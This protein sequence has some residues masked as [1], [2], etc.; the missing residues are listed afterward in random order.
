M[1]TSSSKF[2]EAEAMIPEKLR[3]V[4]KRLVEEYEFVTHS[5]YGRG[6]VAYRVLAELVLGGWRPT[7]SPLSSGKLGSSL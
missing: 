5:Y 6:Y 2:K 4:Y 7:G 1:P 3:P